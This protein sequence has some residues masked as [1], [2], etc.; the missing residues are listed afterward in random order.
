MSEKA[1]IFSILRHPVVYEA[2]QQIFQAE[3]NRKWFAETY[4]RAMP[5]DRVLDIGCGPANLLEHLPGVQY[6]GWEPNPA[7]IETARNKYGDAGVFNVGYFGEAE[8]ATLEPVD[9][10]VVGAVLHHLDDQ[11]ARDLFSLL[12]KV[13]KPGGRVVSLD[14]AFTP[15]QNPIARLLVSLDRGEH[16]RQPEAYTGLASHAFE[17]VSGDLINQRFPPYTFWMMTAR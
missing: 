6:I 4:I 16:Q 2:V 9:I 12:R 5:G 3:R 11:Q 1:G 17:T 13:V 15:H 7:Y 14:C 8:A 10:A